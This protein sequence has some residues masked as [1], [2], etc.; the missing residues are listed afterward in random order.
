MPENTEN[1]D[2]IT[3]A[4][5]AVDAKAL[6]DGVVLAHHSMQLVDF[7]ETLHS[8]RP[9][10]ARKK[11][12]RTFD[13]PGSLIGYYD[14]HSIEGAT[15]TFADITNARIT[16][17]INSHEAD[18]AG[19]G[20][21]KAVLQLRPTADWLEWTGNNEKWLKH[22]NLADFVEKHLTNFV[23]PEG[24]TVLEIVQEFRAIRANSSVRFDSSQ[25][26]K[27][28]QTRIT[29]HETIE[30]KAG[31]TGSIDIPDVLTLAIQV[32]EHGETVGVTARLRYQISDGTL[33]LGYLLDRPTDVLRSVFQTV[34][35]EVSGG[36][37]AP[38]WLGR[39]S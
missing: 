24:A 22:P 39:Q 25:R 13:D 27:S 31:A 6:A 5:E 33:Y 7:W 32:Y 8:R 3:T 2:L 26:V 28:G 35:D 34:C 36:T 14:K 30:A 20:D 4:Q 38:V 11:G 1:H 9:T 18:Y 17:V 21:H 23:A 16:A 10:P 29:Y 15:E 12:T 37:G 19:W